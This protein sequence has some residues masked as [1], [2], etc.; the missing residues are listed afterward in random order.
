MPIISYRLKWLVVALKGAAILGTYVLDE[1]FY[2]N[3]EQKAC[4]QVIMRHALWMHLLL[5]AL[6]AA[7][8]LLLT[9]T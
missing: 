1:P 4:G 3:P 2:V 8:L 7:T 6:V 5:Q 9:L